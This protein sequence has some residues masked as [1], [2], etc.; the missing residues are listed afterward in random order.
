MLNDHAKGRCTLHDE[1]TRDGMYFRRRFRVPFVMF[2]ALI[3]TMLEE[4]WF[5]GFGPRGEGSLD[6]TKLELM[7]GASLQVKVLS[8]LR[9]LGRCVV[10]VLCFA[11]RVFNLTIDA[12]RHRL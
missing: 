11:I 12:Q 2:E 6:A 1:S 7:R 10:C 3:K 8:V 5:S 9:I 4:C